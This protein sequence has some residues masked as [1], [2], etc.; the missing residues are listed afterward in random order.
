MA[1]VGTPREVSGRP[2]GMVGTLDSRTAQRTWNITV[3]STADDAFTIHASVG[4]LLPGLFA[5]HPQNLFFTCR[6]LRY[7]ETDSR[8]HWRAIADYSCSPL[9]REEEERA[10]TPNPMDRALRVEVDSVEFERYATKDINGYG[11]VNSANDPYSAQAVEDSRTV[12]MIERNIANWSGG[13]ELI[14]N[15]LNSGAVTFT[16][17]VTSRTVP[18][19]CGYIKRIRRSSLR[20]ENG[21]VFYIASAEVHVKSDG[22]EWRMHLL[23]EGYYHL[24]TDA[25]KQKKSYIKVWDDETKAAVNTPTE[26]LLDGTGHIL[27]DT[28]SDGVVD[29]GSTGTK[30][31][32]VFIDFDMIREADWS[33]LPFFS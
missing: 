14:N 18:A 7:E 13:W 6:S 19:G 30:H 25:G 32:P 9:S 12:L 17:G 27:D 8:F 23:D 20:K 16:D 15:T 22:E 5:S 11:L 29:F 26:Q 24:Q 28:D 4:G 21:Y 1:V 3:N 10:T 2:G 31:D 33:S